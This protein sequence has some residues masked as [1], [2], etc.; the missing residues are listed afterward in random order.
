MSNRYTRAMATR[1]AMRRERQALT[2]E[3]GGDAAGAKTA[4]MSLSKGSVRPTD[5]NKDPGR[6]GSARPGS[7][8]S[9]ADHEAH[10]A[11][12]DRLERVLWHARHGRTA[13]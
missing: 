10:A 12:L 7:T 5:C 3:T 1:D 9:E 4:D 13:P 11:M 2:V 8:Q 6:P